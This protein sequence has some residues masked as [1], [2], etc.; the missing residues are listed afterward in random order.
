MN[1]LFSVLEHATPKNTRM[2]RFEKK[3]AQVRLDG[4][5]TAFRTQ[6][7]LVDL[8]ITLDIYFSKTIQKSGLDRAT[9]I[10]S[11]EFS[12]KPAPVD[13]CFIFEMDRNFQI[14]IDSIS[15]LFSKI[16]SNGVEIRFLLS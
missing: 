10:I 13:L 1:L 4:L 9:A 3:R 5:P 15:L 16:G 11:K 14:E 8:L 2:F 7:L 6:R 12:G